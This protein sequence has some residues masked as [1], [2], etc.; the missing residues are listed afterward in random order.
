M[1]RHAIAFE[2]LDRRLLFSTSS[3]IAGLWQ[4]TRTEAGLSGGTFANVTIDLNLTQKG[5]LITGTERRSSP[6]DSEYFANMQMHGTLVGQAFDFQDDSITS[7]D[8]P[9]NY[10]WLLYK[11]TLALSPDGQTMTGTWH[12]GRFHGTMTLRRLPLPRLVLNSAA[13]PD[14]QGVT[15]DY[16]VIAANVTQPLRF[17]VYR[18]RTSRVSNTSHLLGTQTLTPSAYS[19]DLAIGRHRVTLLSAKSIP[20][21]ATYRYIIVVANPDGAVHEAAGSVNATRFRN[22]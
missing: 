15:I 9:S 1:L 3:S 12:S 2:S 14:H 4:G 22:R 10:K 8:R 20:R 19:N 18:S 11:V 13:T 6:A 17:D 7:Q 16:S 5:Q 21:D